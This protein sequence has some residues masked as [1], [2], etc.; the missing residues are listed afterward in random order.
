METVRSLRLTSYQT[1]HCNPTAK[2]TDAP[3]N[4]L[5]ANGVPTGPI[6]STNSGSE[7]GVVRITT[8]DCRRRAVHMTL[9]NDPPDV[10]RYKVDAQRGN[11]EGKRGS[12][13]PV[14]DP[15]EALQRRSAIRKHDPVVRARGIDVRTR[16][17]GFRT[18]PIS[19]GT[20]RT[21]GYAAPAF[22]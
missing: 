11:D 19:S 3:A 2:S 4:K 1:R 12:A 15:T 17:I 5:H 10:P 18:R 13:R 9:G 8:R 20:R 6:T 7:G 16:A 22:S 21:T 14:L